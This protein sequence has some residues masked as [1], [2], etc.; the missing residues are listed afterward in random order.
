MRGGNRCHVSRGA[1]KV[2]GKGGR[3]SPVLEADNKSGRPKAS[4]DIASLL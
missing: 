3:A 2:T 1:A 4:E